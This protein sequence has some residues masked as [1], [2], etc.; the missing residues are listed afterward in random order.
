LGNKYAIRALSAP[1][2]GDA[3]AGRPI[4][5]ELLTHYLQ[6]FERPS[7]EGEGKG[8][9]AGEEVVVVTDD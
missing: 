5:D 8:E 7:G 4:T 9:I 2:H 1:L 6:A 3:G